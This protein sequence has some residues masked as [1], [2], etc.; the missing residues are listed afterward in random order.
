MTTKANLK[1]LPQ[2]NPGQS[3]HEY[4]KRLQMINSKSGGGEG[5]TAFFYGKMPIRKSQF[6]NPNVKRDSGHNRQGY[7]KN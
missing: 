6:A 2:P 3:E 5:R 4:E 7:S 1:G